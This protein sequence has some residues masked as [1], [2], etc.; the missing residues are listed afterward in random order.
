MKKNIILGVLILTTPVMLLFAFIKSSGAEKQKLAAQAAQAEAYKIAQE[1]KKQEELKI[2]VM[3]RLSELQAD[4][5]A[6]AEALM[7]C[8]TRK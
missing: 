2:D 4:A 5:E 6:T 1:A 8:Q 7:E 3:E